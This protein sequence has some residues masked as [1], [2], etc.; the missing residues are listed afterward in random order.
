MKPLLLFFNKILARWQRK[1]RVAPQ[2][3]PKLLDKQSLEKVLLEALSAL[4]TIT[5]SQLANNY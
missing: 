4:L 5:H 2:D 3:M 1:W